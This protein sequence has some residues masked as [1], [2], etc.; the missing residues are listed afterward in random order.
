MDR[1]D[2][3]LPDLV[4]RADMVAVSVGPG[5][6]GE[7]GGWLGPLLRGRL[8]ARREPLNVLTFENHRRAPEL[9]AEGLLASTPVAGRRDRPPAGS[10][11]RHGVAGGVPA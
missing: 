5:A 10:G 4:A 8:D 7:V 1:L 9:L 3:G 11:R 2:P 6:L